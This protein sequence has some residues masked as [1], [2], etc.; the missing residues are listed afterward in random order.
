MAALPPTV[1][2][3]GLAEQLMVG[4]GVDTGV[5]PGGVRFTTVVADAVLPWSSATLQVTVIV[6]AV[7]SIVYNVALSSL[8]P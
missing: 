7:T 6:L 1:T 3:A 2:V 4:G 8:P 5:A